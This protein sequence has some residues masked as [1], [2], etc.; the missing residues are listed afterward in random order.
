MTDNVKQTTTIKQL[1]EMPVG[2]KAGGF[3]LTVKKYPSKTVDVDRKTLMPVIFIDETG[4]IPG[5]ILLANKRVTIQK[6]WKV[7]IVICHI[8]STGEGKKLYVEQW[9][10]PTMTI[11]EYEAKQYD[12]QQDIKYGE[13]LH[14]VKSKIRMHIS[15]A[16]INASGLREGIPTLSDSFKKDINEWVDFSLTGE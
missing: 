10:L 16:V 15:E 12:F 4:E 8:Q 7:H 6:G 1:L 11:A 14:I 3:E 5:E 2:E 13:P 9:W